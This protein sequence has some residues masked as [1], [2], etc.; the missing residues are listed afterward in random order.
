MKKIK[1]RWENDRCDK[2]SMVFWCS[3]VVLLAVILFA[4]LK[5][6]TL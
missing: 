3:Y 1:V 4:G 6:T 5:V 2:L